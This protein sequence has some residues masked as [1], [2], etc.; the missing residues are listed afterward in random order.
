MLFA[1]CLYACVYDLLYRLYT[2]QKLVV[3]Y[4]RPFIISFD[5]SFGFLYFHLYY[6]G[7]FHS[8]FQ[9]QV[10]KEDLFHSYRLVY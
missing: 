5:E 2:V 1:F 3:D 6:N 10:Y 9:I 4:N 8:T 7:S